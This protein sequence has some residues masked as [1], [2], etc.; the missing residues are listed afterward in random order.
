VA[1]A[2]SLALARECPHIG[3]TRH[4][5]Y[6]DRRHSAAMGKGRTRTLLEVVRHTRLAAHSGAGE[7]DST[8]M[9]SYGG[10]RLATVTLQ[11]QGAGSRQTPPVSKSQATMGGG[12]ARRGAISCGSS[13][14]IGNCI[15]N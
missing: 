3:Q 14:P 2:T 13:Q 10:P 8:V 11:K 12:R 5:P 15:H 1:E 4:Q 7:G 6:W 9:C